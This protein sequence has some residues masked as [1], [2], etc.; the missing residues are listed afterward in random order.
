M[1]NFRG[2]NRGRKLFLDPSTGQ[3]V[4]GDRDDRDDN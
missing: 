3:V 2:E 1:F 4:G